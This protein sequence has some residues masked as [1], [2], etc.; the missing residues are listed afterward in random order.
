MCLALMSLLKQNRSDFSPN[1]S[2]CC[3]EIAVPVILLYAICFTNRWMNVLMSI[4][5]YTRPDLLWWI[6]WHYVVPH[7]TRLCWMRR[8]THLISLPTMTSQFHHQ[9]RRQIVNQRNLLLK[10]GLQQ[11]LLVLTLLA[12]FGR[13]RL[14]MRSSVWYKYITYID[15]YIYT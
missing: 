1:R 15:I 8:N 5:T 3:K 10:Q 6:L 4:N 9:I 12:L 14:M 13:E 7:C 2:K 11:V